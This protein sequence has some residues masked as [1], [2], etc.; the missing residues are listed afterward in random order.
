MSDFART[1]DEATD[2]ALSDAAADLAR[3]GKLPLQ[4][5]KLAVPAKIVTK[6]Y[7]LKPGEFAVAFAGSSAAKVT[8]PA[9][10]ALGKGAAQ[11]VLVQNQSTTADVQVKPSA[12]DLLGDGLLLT[13]A[14]LTLKPGQH[15]LWMS[16]GK[17]L[18]ALVAPSDLVWPASSCEGDWQRSQ[19]AAHGSET[20]YL[21]NC[22]GQTALG[23]LALVANDLWAVPFRAPQRRGAT[24]DTIAFRVTTLVG[25]SNARIGLYDNAGA[26]DDPYPGALLFDSGN[27][28]T[29]S[30][31][32]KTASVTPA[33][34]TVL[35][36]GALYWLVLHP[37]AAITVDSIAVAGVSHLLGF[38]QGSVALITAIKNSQTFGALPATFPA[39]SAGGSFATTAIPALRRRLAT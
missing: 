2:R 12:K 20:W 8:L 38:S 1:G 3:A 13:A 24:V 36:P 4:Q 35:R 11:L 33:T 34:A 14:S 21:A 5:G 18:W 31:G 39:F 25:A 30:T 26:T 22:G 17:S 10:A 9:A 37:S 28:S 32:D 19:A 27:L 29:A 6:D 7:A 16:D 23:T 15:G